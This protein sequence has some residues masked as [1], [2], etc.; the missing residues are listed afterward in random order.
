[1]DL[2]RKLISRSSLLQ[3]TAHMI[4][5]ST[6]RAL[7]AKHILIL[8]ADYALRRRFDQVA[9]ERFVLNHQPEAYIEWYR[10]TSDSF[11][12]N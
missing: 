3:Q 6:M 4:Q 12:T 11:E 1:M 7:L 10:K 9:R 8:F 2:S 5:S